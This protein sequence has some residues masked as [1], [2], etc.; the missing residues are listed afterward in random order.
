MLSP[1]PPLANPRQHETRAALC[2]ADCGLP[3]RAGSERCPRSHLQRRSV[4][5]PPL[6][7]VLMP[8]SDAPPPPLPP[9]SCPFLL[10]GCISHT[11]PPGRPVIHRHHPGCGSF[12]RQPLHRRSIGRPRRGCLRPASPSRR[13][14]CPRRH[15]PV[16]RG[17]VSAVGMSGQGTAHVRCCCSSSSS[18]SFSFCM[19]SDRE[20]MFPV[21]LCL[22]PSPV[23]V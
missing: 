23:L 20:R 6:S 11:L 10:T 21:H 22:T 19:A 15:L 18:S 7:P 2:R 1:P 17:C 3:R 9:S 5:C 14:H 12:D 16:V 8:T 4:P 13:W